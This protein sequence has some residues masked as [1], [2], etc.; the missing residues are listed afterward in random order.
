[1]FSDV[2][3]ALGGVKIGGTCEYDEHCI[4]GAYCE[5]RSTCRCRGRVYTLSGDGKTCHIRECVD[6]KKY[7][8]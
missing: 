6:I 2:D 5:N 3:E 8:F 7:I 4:E 1:M